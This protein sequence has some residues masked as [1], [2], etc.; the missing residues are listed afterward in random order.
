MHSMKPTD[1][2]K[3]FE[4]FNFA[5]KVSNTAL[6]QY[7]ER[8]KFDGV[9]TAGQYE[10]HLFQYQHD[11]RLKVVVPLILKALQGYE[12]VE[13]YISEKKRSALKKTNDSLEWEIAT[14]C[15]EN[16]VVYREI[17]TVTESLAQLLSQIVTNAG[18]RMNNVA[19]TVLAEVAKDKF[20]EDLK[21]SALSAFYK[22]RKN[23][24][25]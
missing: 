20:G 8:M 6:K 5:P 7:C 1:I 3:I 15:E 19:A 14:I 23:G 16:G 2:K 10:D 24:K 17:D 11:Q 9:L 18:N 21:L 13:D 22:E 4:H 25:I 12:V